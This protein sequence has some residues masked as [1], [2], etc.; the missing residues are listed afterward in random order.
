MAVHWKPSGKN[1]PVADHRDY[2]IWI[3]T[4]RYRELVK[5]ANS[6]APVKNNV[7]RF[8]DSQQPRPVTVENNQ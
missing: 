2:R 7:A 1:V 5:E 6:R 3:E 4:N 8:T